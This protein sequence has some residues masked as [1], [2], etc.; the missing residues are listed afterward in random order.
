MHK[1]SMSHICLTKPVFHPKE[2]Q[3]PVS[4][5]PGCDW[6][7]EESSHSTDPLPWSAHLTQLHQER[8]CMFTYTSPTHQWLSLVCNPVKASHLTIKVCTLTAT[9][10]LAVEYCLC[11]R[12]KRYILTLYLCRVVKVNAKSHE[13]ISSHTWFFFS[14]TR[15][16]PFSMVDRAGLYF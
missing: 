10:T 3:G 8:P 11:W 6:C 12:M 5:W 9:S 4:L 1:Q 14:L 13:Q 7:H 16:L 15:P 2:S